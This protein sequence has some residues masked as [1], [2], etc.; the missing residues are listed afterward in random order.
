MTKKIYKDLYREGIDLFISPNGECSFIYL[1]QISLLHGA[2]PPARLWNYYGG[3]LFMRN[4][5]DV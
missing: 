2:G 3:C 5:N 1:L 4:A